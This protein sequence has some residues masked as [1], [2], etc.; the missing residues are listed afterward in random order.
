MASSI[1]ARYAA[2]VAAG[3]VERDAAQ[4]AVVDQLARLEERIVEYRLARKSSSLGW[5]FAVRSKKETLLKG[6][7]IYGDVGRGKTM[8]MDLFFEVSPVQRKRR[9]HFH[10]FMIDVHERV[11]GLRQKMTVGEYAG[12]D[13]IALAA[14]ELAREA[15]LLCF[16]EFHVTDIADAMILGRLFA[17]LFERGVVVV[18]TS[19]VP[20]DDLYRDGLNRA[21][22]VPFIHMLETHMDIVRLA[23]RTDFRLE[24]LAGRP[25]WY[26]PAEGAADAALDDAWLRLTAGNGGVPQQLPLKGRSVHVPRAAMGVARFAFG[27]LCEQP[28]AASDYLRIAREYHTIILDHVPVMTFDNRNAAK[29]FINL[30]DTLYDMNVKLIASAE[31]EP[32]M[33]YRAEEGFEAQE[34]K[35]TASR[36]IEMRSQAYLA[37]PHG[38]AHSLL[39]GSSSGIVET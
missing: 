13:P 37:R 39:S 34:F 16:D 38:A 9:V 28:L 17:Q 23:S 1:I 7:Y 2:G 14:K 32:E 27:D 19:N 24:K 18:A 26:V 4:V 6:L 15:W 11:H 10:E 5:L 33:L 31:A 22:F 8:L 25:V 3:K 21:L 35:R 36:L 29:R 20:P 30:I 12:E